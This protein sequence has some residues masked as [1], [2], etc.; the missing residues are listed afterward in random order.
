MN[1]LVE[2]SNRNRKNFLLNVVGCTRFLETL[3]TLPKFAEIEESDERIN[4]VIDF[5]VSQYE[6]CTKVMSMFNGPEDRPFI[7]NKNELINKNYKRNL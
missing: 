5:V 3:Q 6:L 7:D 2:A 1:I 4:A